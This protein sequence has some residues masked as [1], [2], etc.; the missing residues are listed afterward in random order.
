MKQFLILFS[1]TM[2]IVCCT[3]R[4]QDNEKLAV[5]EKAIANDPYS[6]F[7]VHDRTK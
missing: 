2:T 7:E 6:A 4:Q 3:Q 1:L 5:V